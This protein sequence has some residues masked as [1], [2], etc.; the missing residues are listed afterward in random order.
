MTEPTMDLPAAYD[1]V[2]TA[3][4]AV[5]ASVVEKI[6]TFRADI[7]ALA[8]SLPPQAGNSHVMRQ[9][10][11]ITSYLFSFDSIRDALNANYGLLAQPEGE[12]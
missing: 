6:E 10:G 1:I 4:K 8:A 9:M 5:A 2:Q 3:E 7:E 12:V 11:N